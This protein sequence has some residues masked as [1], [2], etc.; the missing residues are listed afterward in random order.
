MPDQEVPLLM[1]RYSFRIPR[2]TP[3]N[4]EIKGMHWASYRALRKLFAQEVF[5][6]AGRPSLPPLQKALLVIQRG[7]AGRGLDWDNA[8]GGLKPLLDCLVV[9]SSRNPDGLGFIENDAPA[10]LLAAP[11]LLQK[12]VPLGADFTRVL[13][14]DVL[15]GF[16]EQCQPLVLQRQLLALLSPEANASP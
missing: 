12:S 13:I 14:L 1:A 2:R 15:S 11:L 9:A 5:V 16:G 4:N 10:C 3:S 6:A 7:S 8:Y